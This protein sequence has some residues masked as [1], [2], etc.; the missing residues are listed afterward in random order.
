MNPTLSFLSSCIHVT[1][2]SSFI[3]VAIDRKG[4]YTYIRN[5]IEYRYLR[6][7]IALCCDYFHRG[8]FKGQVSH[9]DSM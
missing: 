2:S 1:P 4:L 3:Y 6:D 9:K 7:Y 8:E 5:Y